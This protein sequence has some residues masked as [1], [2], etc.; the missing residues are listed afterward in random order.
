MSKRVQFINSIS[1]LEG[2]T[3]PATQDNTAQIDALTAAGCERLFSEKPW[4][5]LQ[6]PSRTGQG[7]EGIIAE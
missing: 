3:R 5:I 7:N 6:W 1:S 2:H 4:Q